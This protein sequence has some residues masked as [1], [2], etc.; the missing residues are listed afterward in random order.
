MPWCIR[1]TQKFRNILGKILDTKERKIAA[2]N[3]WLILFFHS[4]LQALLGKDS[5]RSSSFFRWN[6]CQIHWFSHLKLA[7]I[8]KHFDWLSCGCID[9][10]RCN[11]CSRPQWTQWI[12]KKICFEFP[13][14]LVGKSKMV[15]LIGR[16]WRLQKSWYTGGG[17]EKDSGIVMAKV[18]FCLWHRW[19]HP[20]LVFNLI[21]LDQ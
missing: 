7:T 14:N 11:P 19:G 9:I 16:S 4:F 3:S 20:W 2:W 10:L 17:P 21:S 12:T 5:Q 1:C 18:K 8:I 15:I 6:K 13:F